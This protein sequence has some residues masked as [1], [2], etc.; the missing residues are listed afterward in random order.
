MLAQLFQVF[1]LALLNFRIVRR[2]IAPAGRSKE[3]NLAALCI[4]EFP[5]PA[6]RLELHE[7]PFHG[8]VA[9]AIRSVRDHLVRFCVWRQAIDARGMSATFLGAVTVSGITVRS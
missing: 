9:A 8:D 2:W 3:P 4:N 1:I 6:A 7:F 5:I